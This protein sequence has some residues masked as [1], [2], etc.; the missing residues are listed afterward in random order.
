MRAKEALEAK[1]L[2]SKVQPKLVYGE[3]I[4]QAAQ[5][6]YTGNAQVGIIALSLAMSP[7]YASKGGYALIPAALH[8]PLEQGFIITKRAAGNPAAL[9]FAE[10]MGSKTVRAVMTRYGFV[11]PGEIAAQ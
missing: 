10:Y 9:R 4:G 5:F 11:L 8:Q 2:W 1:G 7:T 3:S 6:A